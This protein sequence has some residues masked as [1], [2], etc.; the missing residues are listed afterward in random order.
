MKPAVHS[1]SPRNGR[2]VCVCASGRWGTRGTAQPG[3]SPSPR[4]L[5]VTCFF[6]ICHQKVPLR[7]PRG[8]KPVPAP[9]ATLPG[10]RAEWEGT[11][12][13]GNPQSGLET[14]PCE[15]SRL[16]RSGMPGHQ[17]HSCPPPSPSS[18]LSRKIRRDV[19]AAGINSTL[20]RCTQERSCPHQ[21]HPQIQWAPEVG[22]HPTEP[23][24]S[25]Q[26]PRRSP[27][28]GSCEHSAPF[29]LEAQCAPV[30]P[31]SPARYHE[32]GVRADPGSAGS[33]DAP[34]R[35]SSPVP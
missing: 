27:A 17:L 19:R 9:L 30:Q 14:D 12:G 20:Q 10:H 3:G 35:G 7:S 31:M 32:L 11:P 21:G 13:I 34:G 26:D 18:A 22:W 2:T 23:V 1:P 6:N 16:S 5:S 15:S 25:P 24:C 28:A 29:P 4:F 33:R 8:P